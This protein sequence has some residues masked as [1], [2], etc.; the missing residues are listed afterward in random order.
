MK[1]FSLK[2]I[3]VLFLSMIMVNAQNENVNSF[4]AE[5]PVLIT[6]SG[7]SADI[8]MV[9]ILAKKSSLDYVMKKSASIEDLDNKKSI[10]IVSGGSTKGLGAAKIDKEEE[11]QRTKSI[12]DAAKEKNIKVIAV[13]VGGK[14]RR[15]ALSDYFNKVV[16]ENADHLIV[17]SSGDQ[18]S[19]F[20]NIASEKGIEI[21]H[22]EKIVLI[23]DILKRIYSK[24]VTK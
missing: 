5:D 20:T 23:T 10:M 9:K 14:S 18:D 16:A 3:M 24:E 13:H 22:A 12:I 11:Y 21:D 15:G 7:Q 19:Y 6:S 1:K 8:L 4:K 17:V 2:V